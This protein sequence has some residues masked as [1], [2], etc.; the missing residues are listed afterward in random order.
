MRKA[1]N[2]LNVKLDALDVSEVIE[3][4]EQWI[5]SSKRVS[6]KY[7]CVTNVNSVVEAKNNSYLKQITNQSDISVCDGMPLVWIGRLKGFKLRERVYGFALM[8]KVLEITREKGYKNYF[9]GST[10]S[11]LKKMLPHIKAEY[12]GVKISGMHSPPFRPLTGTEKREI[13]EDINN[14][15]ADIVWVGLGYPKQEIWMYE[16]K[17]YIKCP[18]LIGVGAAFDFYSGN[19][20]Q[21]PGWMQNAGLEWLFRFLH[22]PRRLWKRYL[23]NNTIFILFMIKDVLSSIPFFKTAVGLSN[24]QG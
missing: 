15:N 7:I 20:R 12:P 11:V 14:S 1:F 22:E 3:K 24:K 16:F 4:I 21:A 23:V 5:L 18:V 6:A 2:V 9:Y 17:D 8:K 10:E 19:K 13:I